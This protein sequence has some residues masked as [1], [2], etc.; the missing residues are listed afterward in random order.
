MTLRG[1]R[2]R[3]DLSSMAG[4]PL[5][6]GV[7]LLAQWVEGGRLVTLLQ[8][9]AALTVLGGTTVAMLLS[10]PLSTLVS[11][12]HAVVDLFRPPPPSNRTLIAAFG[13]FASVARRKGPR[14]L[15]DEISRLS[16][17][18]LARSLTLAIDGVP[19]VEIRHVLDLESRLR[20]DADEESAHVLETAAGYAPT[21][22]ILG[23]VLGLVH[24]MDNLASPAKVGV[25]IAAAF[26]A[27]IY[28]LGTANLIFLPLATKLRANA[29]A[30]A[31]RRGIIIE[32]VVAMQQGM[33]PRLVEERLEA[34]LTERRPRLEVV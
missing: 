25:G 5:A 14:T 11:S 34:L 10:F 17:A 31:S 33:H 6:I 7:I 27:T 24:V 12:A 32:G 22:G 15:E 4:V 13:E 19:I 8:P 1:I 30:A 16:D 2:Q 9:A 23:A 18:F 20:E 3:F 26:V 28:G 29:R 21:L